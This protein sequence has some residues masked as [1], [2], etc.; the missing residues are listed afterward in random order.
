ML[1]IGEGGQNHLRARRAQPVAVV[2]DACGFG[3]FPA[4]FD[5]LS[6]GRILLK[7]RFASRLMVAGLTPVSWATCSAVEIKVSF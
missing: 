1:A 2:T 4:G 3:E 7:L 5:L 6:F